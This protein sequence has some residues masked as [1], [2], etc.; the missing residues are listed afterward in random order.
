MAN[1]K[2]IPPEPVLPIV[3]GGRTRPSRLV[4]LSPYPAVAHRQ[5][6]N[7]RLLAGLCGQGGPTATFSAEDAAILLKIARERFSGEHALLRRRALAAL[8]QT[9]SLDA[10]ES[11]SAIALSP[12]EDESAR[13]AALAAISQ[14]VPSVGT[15]LGVLLRDDREPLVRTRARKSIAAAM[16]PVES[17]KRRRARR[18]APARDR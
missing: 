10:I 12:L 5:S 15:G 7:T 16:E 18:T 14:A 2:Q 6:V 3:R 13:A 11:L 4:N 9:R 1:I 8:A 17:R